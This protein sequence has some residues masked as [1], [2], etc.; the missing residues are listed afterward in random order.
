MSAKGLHIATI[1]VKMVSH[2]LVID[3]GLVQHDLLQ[4]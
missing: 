4:P 2:T 1:P 3:H